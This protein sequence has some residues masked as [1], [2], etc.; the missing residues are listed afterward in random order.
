MAIKESVSWVCD[1][2]L[3][4]HEWVT[5]F[6]ISMHEEVL[7]ALNYVIDVPCVVQWGLLWFP[8]HTRL[9]QICVDNDTEIAKYHEFINMAI[10][11]RSLC[12][13]ADSTRQDRAC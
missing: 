13:L 1:N 6:T 2:A 8:S 3:E 12:P 5:E 7:V 10:E 9:N 11:L 4:D